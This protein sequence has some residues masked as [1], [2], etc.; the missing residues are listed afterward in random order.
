M[1]CLAPFAP[2]NRYEVAVRPAGDLGSSARRSPDEHKLL[3]F[4]GVA[5]P[6]AGLVDYVALAA[7][8]G[9]VALIVRHH[10]NQRKSQ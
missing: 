6:P 8:A 9:A 4:D 10:H 1:N 3:W 7:V 5:Y 2:V